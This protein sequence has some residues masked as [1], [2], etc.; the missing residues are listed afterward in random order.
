MGW[1]KIPCP[2]C[3]KPMCNVSELCARCNYDSQIGKPKGPLVK[4][5]KTYRMTVSETGERKR[6]HQLQAEKALG[7][8][9]KRPECTHHFELVKNGGQLVI[10]P[11]DAYHMLLHYRARAKAATGDPHKKW[12]TN[13]KKWDDASRLLKRPDANNIWYHPRKGSKCKKYQPTL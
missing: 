12:C 2:K 4:N 5:P 6:T 10:C 13:C 11:D 3:G 8:P 7:R 9:L 1:T